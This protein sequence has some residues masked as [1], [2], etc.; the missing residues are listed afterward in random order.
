MLYDSLQFDQGQ[1]H[2]PRAAVY[3]CSGESRIDW[4]QRYTVRVIFSFGLLAVLSTGLGSCVCR[5]GL[6]PRPRRV[7]IKDMHPDLD[8]HATLKRRVATRAR[9]RIRVLEGRRQ[10]ARA[11]RTCR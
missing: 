10:A 2:V 5:H 3:D 6:A 8:Q 7:V 9:P 4:Y 1:Y 11:A